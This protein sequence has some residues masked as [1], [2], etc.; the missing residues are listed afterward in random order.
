MQG[1]FGRL[2]VPLPI[3]YTDHCAD[4][5]EGCNRLFNVRTQRVGLNQIHTVYMP[6][7]NA[8]KEQEDIW[9][10]FKDMLFSTQ[11]ENDRV[12]QYHVHG[13]E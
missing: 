3:N 1:T 2:R 6:I 12:L 7:W 13:L 9:N 11:R 10:H 4:L 8:N 5:L